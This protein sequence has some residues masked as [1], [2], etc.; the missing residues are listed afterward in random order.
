M[1]NCAAPDRAVWRG[2]APG[3]QKDLGY[4]SVQEQDATMVIL[5]ESAIDAIS[6]LSAPS[7][8]SLPFHIRSSA[9]PQLYTYTSYPSTSPS[10]VVLIPTPQATPFLNR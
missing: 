7:F 2:M 9:V 4:F 10:I 3:S 5:C 6:C 1:P 8:F